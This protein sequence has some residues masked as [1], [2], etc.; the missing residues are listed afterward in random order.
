MIK[1]IKL[2]Y[3]LV[4]GKKV[5]IMLNHL[6][7]NEELNKAIDNLIT[8]IYGSNT[9]VPSTRGTGGVSDS[10]SGE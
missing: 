5:S 8:A 1:Y 3:E 10:D 9:K 7:K 6:E 4:S 2:D